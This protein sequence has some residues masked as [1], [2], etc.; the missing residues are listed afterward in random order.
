M[1]LFIH[2]IDHSSNRI[3]QIIHLENK[4]TSLGRCCLKFETSILCLVCVCVWVWVFYLSLF[5]FEVGCLCQNWRWKKKANLLILIESDIIFDYWFNMRLSNFW[6]FSSI[7]NRLKTV[8][9]FTVAQNRLWADV[10]EEE[11]KKK[12]WF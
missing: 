4:A 8:F 12:L 3:N 6:S 11:V 5:D 7:F 2:Y 10:W 1:G 9:L